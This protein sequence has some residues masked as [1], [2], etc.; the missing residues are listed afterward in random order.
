VKW[1]RPGRPERATIRAGLI[2][3]AGLI[4]AFVAGGGAVA[5]FVEWRSG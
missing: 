5:L 4:L 3:T 1:F 2:L